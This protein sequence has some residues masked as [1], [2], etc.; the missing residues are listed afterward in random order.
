MRSA[1]DSVFSA[2]QNGS[3]HSEWMQRTLFI[4]RA[5]SLASIGEHNHH[6]LCFILTADDYSVSL[7]LYW[8]VFL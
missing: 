2:A 3:V 7:D 4:A 5:V 8:D 6:Q 1:Q